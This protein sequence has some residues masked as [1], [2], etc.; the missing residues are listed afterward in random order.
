M[1][2]K[3][4]CVHQCTHKTFNKILDIFKD[5]NCLIQLQSLSLYLCCTLLCVVYP[6]IA[7][8]AIMTS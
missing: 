8:E 1:R 3:G 6:I 4:A 7:V 2:A 5:K